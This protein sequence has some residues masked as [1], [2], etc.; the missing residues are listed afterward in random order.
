MLAKLVMLAVDGH[1]LAIEEPAQNPHRFF[2]ALHSHR[3][4]IETQPDLGVLRRGMAS[5]Q[6]KL[7]AAPSEEVH[8][9]GLAGQ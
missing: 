9:R 5:T 3:R 8:G 6:T 4:P 2:E 1:R 7:K